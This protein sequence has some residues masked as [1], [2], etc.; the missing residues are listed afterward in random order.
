[1]FILTIT[2]QSRGDRPSNCRAVSSNENWFRKVEELSE[3][4]LVLL[5]YEWVELPR[6]HQLEMFTETRPRTVVGIGSREHHNLGTLILS[7]V[8]QRFEE[9]GQ[10]GYSPAIQPFWIVHFYSGHLFISL[11]QNE[12]ICFYTWLEKSSW[13][14]HRSDLINW[15]NLDGCYHLYREEMS[16]VVMEPGQTSL[17]TFTHS[18]CYCEHSTPTNEDAPRLELISLVGCV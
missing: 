8:I 9:R 17:C 16:S 15:R 13:R 10:H 7:E 2:Q 11:R 3:Q 18:Q 12:I 5:G 1:M 6:V 14:I 4:H